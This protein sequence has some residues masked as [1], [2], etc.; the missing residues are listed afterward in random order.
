[1]K[2]LSAAYKADL[3]IGLPEIVVTT[4]LWVIEWM[5]PAASNVPFTLFVSC[6]L[7]KESTEVDSIAS[8]ADLEPC[9]TVEP[10]GPETR[11]EAFV[12]FVLFQICEEGDER[13]EV[14]VL[15]EGL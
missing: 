8:L 5:V 12:P 4:L 15:M 14:V 11:T 7:G 1:M 3:V 13:G 2:P 6:E 9:T 10:D